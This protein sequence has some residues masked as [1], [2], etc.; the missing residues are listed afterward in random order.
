MPILTSP[1]D[2]EAPY[3]ALIVA[4]KGFASLI[5]IFGP[6]VTELIDVAAKAPLERRTGEWLTMVAE[7]LND[8]KEA[9]GDPEKLAANP[10]FATA[11]LRASQA[12]IRTHEKDKLLALRNA[13]VNL[14]TGMNADDFALHV[15]LDAIDSLSALHIQFLAV[16][17]APGELIYGE[18]NP[19]V[20]LLFPTRIPSVSEG[21]L[22]ANVVVKRAIADLATYGLLPSDLEHFFAKEGDT[23]G[24]AV[25][26]LGEFVLTLIADPKRA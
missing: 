6:W 20:L 14:A 25:T 18:I 10:A 2:D 9:I 3:K 23:Y 13:V 19:S 4:G 12:A 11:F 24:S 8:V 22:P 7:A 1:P 26:P 15:A 5:P 21:A 17:K 16:A